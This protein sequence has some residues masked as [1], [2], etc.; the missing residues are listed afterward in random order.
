MLKNK[1]LY[2]WIFTISVLFAL[3]LPTL[4]KDGMFMDGL[5]YSCI[6]KNLS[7]GIGSFWAPQYSR[8][9]YPFFNQQ[10]PLGFGIQSLFFTAF[11]CSMYVER[12]YSLL[13]AL[14]TAYLIMI[15]WETILKSETNSRSASWFPILLWIT[16]PVCFWSYA[17]NILENTM[18]I[19]DLISIIYIS[20]YLFKERNSKYI[21]LSGI[22]IFLATMTKG[23]QGMFPLAAL[24]LAWAVYR[25]PSFKKM[26]YGSVLL[27]IVPAFTYALL[28]SNSFIYGNLSSYFT[29]R[30]LHSIKNVIEVNSRFYIAKRL[31][32]ELIPATI[33]TAILVIAAQ[34]TMKKNSVVFQIP[35]FRHILFFFLIGISASLPLMVTMEQR[36]F[37]LTTS[38]P[39]FAVAIALISVTGLIYLIDKIN[40]D[41][42]IYKI[43]K[44]FTIVLLLVVFTFSFLQL[45]KRSRDH[46]MLNDIYLIGAKVPQGTIVGSTKKL[47]HVWSLQEYLVRY[48]NIY[49]KDTISKTDNYIII[50][51]PKEI[52]VGLKTEKQNIPTVKYQLYKILK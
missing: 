20:K 17:N 22:F 2:F 24:F 35:Y 52:P 32:F 30:V 45:G 28:L 1:Q 3:I 51:A 43:F 27:L 23:I 44:I 37:Y 36:G 10:P 34:R 31:L 8:T 19:F 11:G 7:N 42:K 38:L 5:L 6:S 48:F 46:Q 14:V 50:E 47:W 41:S 18:G 39:Y 4:I 13:C 12:F 9:L 33:L 40:V 21:I 16:I 25:N 26:V 49:M 29:H 15:L